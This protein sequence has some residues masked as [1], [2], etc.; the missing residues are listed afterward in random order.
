LEENVDKLKT[1]EKAIKNLNPQPYTEDENAIIVSISGY[2]VLIDKED[3]DRVANVGL[4]HVRISNAV[5]FCHSINYPKV[6]HIKL[7]RFIMNPPS[8]MQV[9]HASGDTLDNRKV[10][11]RICT[12]AENQWNRKKSINNTSGYKGVYFHRGNGKW[13]AKIK[14]NNKCL[15]IGYFDTPEKAYKAYC[16]ASEKYHGEFGRII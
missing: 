15:H 9:D 14:L 3:L 12:H 6:H 10:N 5:Y 8:N 7:H 16:E 2:K 11:L 4:W 13:R 1:R